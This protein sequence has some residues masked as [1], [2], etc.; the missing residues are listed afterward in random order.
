MYIEKKK[1]SISK[2]IQGNSE[3]HWK[4]SFTPPVTLPEETSNEDRMSKINLL[5]DYAMAVA[6]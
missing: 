5:A 2:R 1:K 4:V 6:E 3:N